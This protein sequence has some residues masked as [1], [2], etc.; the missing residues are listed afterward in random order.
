[1][2][3]VYSYSC[4]YSY[5]LYSYFRQHVVLRRECLGNGAALCERW[6]DVRWTLLALVLVREVLHR[7]ATALKTSRSTLPCA[8]RPWSGHSWMGWSDA[9]FSLADGCSKSSSLCV[10]RSFFAS[11]ALFLLPSASCALLV[12]PVSSRKHATT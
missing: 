3:G 1:M 11:T 4:S 8:A 7:L 9:R 12:S 10:H 2:A 6:V 5:L